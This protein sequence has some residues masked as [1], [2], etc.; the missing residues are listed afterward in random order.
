MFPGIHDLQ[1]LKAAPWWNTRGREQLNHV[2]M[3][4]PRSQSAFH[5]ALYDPNL[6][7]LAYKLE[8]LGVDDTEGK[9]LFPD[10]EKFRDASHVFLLEFADYFDTEK[11]RS[12]VVF[13]WLKE[14]FP[15]CLDQ[16]PDENTTAKNSLKASAGKVPKTNTAAV[17]KVLDDQTV[18]PRVIV[19]IESRFGVA[20]L[21]CAKDFGGHILTLEV[22]S[23]CCRH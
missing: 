14:I 17:F 18:I 10:A 12:D 9:K 11:E 21:Q 16:F 19:E 6:A 4:H 15:D 22:R 5:V 20:V 13:Q 23:T 1:Q 2:F 3:G 7:L 8:R